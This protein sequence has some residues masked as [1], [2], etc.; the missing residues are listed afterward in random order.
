MVWLS[1]KDLPL[2][3]ESR[4][5]APHFVGPFPVSKVINPTAVRLK[6]PRSLRVHPTFHV[7]WIK[8]VMERPLVPASRPPPPPRFIHGGPA[9]TVKRLLAVRRRGHGHQYLVDWQGYGPEERIWV[10]SSNIMDPTLIQDFHRC[11]PHQLDTSGAVP[12]GGGT[13]V[14]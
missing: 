3:V 10:S 11:H 2:R 12:R 1:S 5:L 13:V 9:F 8:P 7:A 4:K 6:L 14:S